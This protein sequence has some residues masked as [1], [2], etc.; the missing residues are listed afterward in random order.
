[1]PLNNLRGVIIIGYLMIY[2]SKWQL[3]HTQSSKSSKIVILPKS[4]DL[5]QLFL[6]GLTDL[7]TGFLILCNFSSLRDGGWLPQNMWSLSKRGS[8]IVCSSWSDH[9]EDQHLEEPILIR[10][11][12]MSLRQSMLCRVCKFHRSACTVFCDKDSWCLESVTMGHSLCMLVE[13]FN[14]G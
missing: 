10:F 2:C 11:Q 13:T 1:M 8:S 5:F 9:P 3:I 12:L 4:S 7:T 6:L 14:I